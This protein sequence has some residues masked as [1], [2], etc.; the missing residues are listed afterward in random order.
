MKVGQLVELLKRIDPNLEA[1]IDY[2]GSFYKINKIISPIMCID[3]HSYSVEK[4]TQCCE[5]IYDEYM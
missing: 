2:D 4:G 5:I 1:V 3:G